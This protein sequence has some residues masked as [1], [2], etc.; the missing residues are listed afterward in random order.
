M[1]NTNIRNSVWNSVEAS[2]RD[3]VWVSV[4]VSVRDSVGSSV[5]DYFS[6]KTNFDIIKQ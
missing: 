4:G 3:S 6:N 1:T 5:G 2:V